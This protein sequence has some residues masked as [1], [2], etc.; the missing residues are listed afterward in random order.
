MNRLERNKRPQID[1]KSLRKHSH[2]VSDQKDPL[3]IVGNR[4]Q[5]DYGYVVPGVTNK[6]FE[7]FYM[8]V[9][10]NS[11]TPVWRHAKKVRVFRVVAG[12]GYYQEFNDSEATVTRPLSAG[13]EFIADS[14]V[15][16]RLTSGVV[17]LELYVTQES[18][19]AAHLDEVTP[20]EVVSTVAAEE[21]LAVTQQEKRFTLGNSSRRDRSSRAA[22]QI[23]ELRGQPV[24]DR[25]N[26]EDRTDKF[27]R[28]SASTGVNAMP[29]MDFSQEGAG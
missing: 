5:T 7:T 1:P 6:A 4:E 11:T 19:Y 16:Y 22:Q 2:I 18:K 27:L 10:P 3:L 13:D 24:K 21:L 20:A 26:G 23:A 28:N 17:K 9:V 14:N 8:A 29:V 15:S 12:S 25:S